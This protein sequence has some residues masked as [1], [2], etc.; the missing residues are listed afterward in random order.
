MHLTPSI[1]TELA[2]ILGF[3]FKKVIGEPLTEWLSSVVRANIVVDKNFSIQE[4]SLER[5]IEYLELC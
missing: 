2:T 4:L 5:E 1:G 3:N